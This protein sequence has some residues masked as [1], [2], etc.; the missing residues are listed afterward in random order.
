MIR[1]RVLGLCASLAC[2]LLTITAC[3]PRSLHPDVSDKAVI[4]LL[5]RAA[6]PSQVIAKIDDRELGL[7]E[8]ERFWREHPELERQAAIDAFIAREL[9]LAQ[10][11]KAPVPK[12]APALTYARKRGLVDAWLE[13]NIERPLAVLPNPQGHQPL[14]DQVEQELS[15][16]AGLVA[17]HLLVLAPR[18][19]KDPATQKMVELTPEQRK[20]LLDQA[21]TFAREQL[22]PRIAGKPA[23]TLVLESLR[24][25]LASEAS[26]LGL[27]LI[28]NKQMRFMRPDQPRQVSA[29]PVGWINPVPAFVEA[30]DALARDK[31]L[32]VVSE[33]IST[34]FGA[35]LIL[36]DQEIPAVTPPAA[37][38]DALAYKRALDAQRTQ[39]LNERTQAL[40]KSSTYQIFPRALEAIAES[41]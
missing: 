8:F 7:A 31:G 34:P 18:E 3:E 9:L 6:K 16:P 29:L 27:S 41:Q 14:R 21:N 35:H 5:D 1:A 13:V 15:Q 26:A 22:A 36:I 17:S 32:G 25:E 38:V 28:V 40:A 12:R 19:Y 24:D 23:T 4:G 10:A 2:G 11:L 39:A 20:P 33:V 37:Q 30:A